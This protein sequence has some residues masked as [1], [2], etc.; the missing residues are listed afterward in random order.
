MHKII[1]GLGLQSSSHSNPQPNLNGSKLAPNVALPLILASLPFCVQASIACLSAWEQ[2]GKS[3]CVL[4]IQTIAHTTIT[5]T[6]IVTGSVTAVKCVS[7]LSLAYN[8]L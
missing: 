1:Y 3:S 8:F 6:I 4:P 7:E 2:E 5:T